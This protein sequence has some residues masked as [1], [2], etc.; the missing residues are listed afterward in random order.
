MALELKS[1]SKTVGA[2][3]HIH[4]TDLRLERGTMNVLLGRTLSGKTTLMRIMAGLDVPETGSVHWD[5]DDVTGKRV[6]D[7]DVAM[8]YQQFIN[9][10]SMTVYDNIASPLRLRQ[11]AK[12]EID[13][14]VRETATLMKLTNDQLFRKPLELS[15]GQQQRCALARALVKNAGLV[16]LDE[17]LANLDYKLREELRTEIPKI[18][19]ASGAIFV[20][21]T[22]EPH[23]ALLLGGNTACLWEGRITQFGSTPEVYRKPGNTVTAGVFS[24]PPMNFVEVQKRGATITQIDTSLPVS[25]DLPDL[26]DGRYRFGFRANHLALI[27][28]SSNAVSFECKCVGTEITGSESFVH[29]T[30]Q[31]QSWVALQHGVVHDI[32]AGERV[33][34]YLN[35]I[36]AY[37]FAADDTLV[38]AARY[39]EAA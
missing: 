38:A 17:P 8:V 33:M 23:E 34:A 14:A 11:M 15:G 35:P 25:I 36:H 21:A 39:A 19:E 9:Y 6:Q 29:L 22:T 4:P 18:F 12:A 37:V 16:L 2:D 3:V 13:N 30:H 24:D 5:G 28:P 20:Y 1:V 27:P 7:R 31:G 26:G 10:P 32:S